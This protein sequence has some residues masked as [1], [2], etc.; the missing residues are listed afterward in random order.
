MALLFWAVSL[1]QQGA[2]TAGEVVLVCTLGLTILHATRD[3]AVAL[4]DVTQHTA[5]LAE[6]LATLL[7]PHEL[8]N[9]P[10]AGRSSD[11]GADHHLRKRRLRLSRRK[12][13]FKDFDLKIQA[14]EWVGLDRPLGLRQV[15]AGHPAAALLRRAGRAHPIDGQDIGRVTQESLRE[16]MTVVPQ[17]ISLFHRTLRENIR[18]GRPDATDEEVW[19]AAGAARCTEFIEPVP[20]GFDTIVGDRGVKLSGGQRQRIAI[21]RAFLK[22]AP[23]LIL[24]EATSALDSASE[25]AIREALGN[26]MK[27]RTVIAIAHRLLDAQRLRSD[28]GAP[29]R[30]HHPGRRARAPDP[31]RGLLPRTRPEGD[32]RADQGS[33]LTR[34]PAD[35]FQ[36]RAISSPCD[37]EVWGRTVV[38]SHAVPPPPKPSPQGESR[39]YAAE[40]VDRKQRKMSGSALN[41]DEG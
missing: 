1:W 14:G 29:E 27:G 25:E 11:Q 31:P 3:L 4:V 15:D 35:R 18:Y 38:A 12:G 16:A 26:L 33:R 6:A 8:T 37:E 39:C 5:R 36:E 19:Q 22:N 20:E 9:H 2:A 41:L 32:D 7:L 40:R 17:D 21:A 30:A 23:I 10:E 28:R 34:V 24:D 13:V